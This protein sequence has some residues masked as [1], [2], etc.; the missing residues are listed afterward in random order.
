[1]AESTATNATDSTKSKIKIG[2][3]EEIEVS[4]T[5]FEQA[6]R[7]NRK[8][9]VALAKSN[10]FE[11]PVF[12]SD[13]VR[14]DFVDPANCLLEQVYM[15]YMQMA[16][17]ISQVVDAG[18]LETGQQ[19]HRFKTDTNKYVEYTD[20][21]YAHDACH[22]VIETDG[23]VVECDM[24][25]L[26]DNISRVITEYCAH[27]PLSEFNHYFQE[28]DDNN[29]GG[30]STDDNEASKDDN[31]NPDDINTVN[32]HSRSAYQGSQVRRTYKDDASGD[33]TVTTM[34][35]PSE[36]DMVI[37][38]DKL[39]TGR[40]AERRAREKHNYDTKIKSAQLVDESK[41]QKL[42]T[43]KPLMMTVNF[44]VKNKQTG[45]SAPIEYVVGIKTH[46][47]LID[48]SIL[49][50]MAQYPLKEMNKLSRKAKWRA[51]EINFFEYLF[52][53]KGKKQTAIDS[54]DPKRKWY[55]R[56]YEL[57]HTGSDI[58]AQKATTGRS[59]LN[60]LSI[61]SK[62]VEDNKYEFTANAILNQFDGV[63]PNTTLVISMDD[64]NNVKR[65]TNIDLLKGSTAKKLCKEMFLIGIVVIDSD[66][67][68]L[69]M[70][71]PDIH[72]DYEVHS[73]AA[74]NRQLA[75]LDTSGV[76]AADISKILG[77]NR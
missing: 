53:I 62:K 41:I 6:G 36:M 45:V 29:S 72:N 31:R 69:K 44:R 14:K 51:G 21:S 17:S 28:A 40:N 59:I 3:P 26:P 35:R 24:I 8:S 55:R 25:S 10:I 43:L 42:N 20:M 23:Y 37:A 39:I 2:L 77:R 60:R 71:L 12:M 66:E 27:E 9:I 38:H 74:L 33:I 47:R 70:M 19:F 48:A 76:S 13:T 11:F 61:G 49:P 68:T 32:T 73:L 16:F 57:A 56:L 1:M 15:S 63:M 34:T 75:T 54:A 52:N 64:V 50:E 67:E 7:V 22:N 5:D 58:V 65:Q 30:N 18:M 46:T 4:S